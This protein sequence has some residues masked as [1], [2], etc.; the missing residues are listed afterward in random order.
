M[1]LHGKSFRYFIPNDDNR[2][3][4]GRNLREMFILNNRLPQHMWNETQGLDC[5]MLELF[6]SLSY[7]CKELTD[8]DMNISDWFWILIR[9]A[10]LDLCDDV[11]YYT[12]M[13][14]NGK[15]LWADNEVN[16]KLDKI[17]NRTYRRNGIGGLFP[18]RHAKNDQR[19]IELWYQMCSYLEENYA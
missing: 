14:V 9:N 10:G 1:I 16:H 15:A 17:I 19:T 2:A 3:F 6:I 11:A 5:S 12:P 8:N 18:L 7:R 13:N 4:E